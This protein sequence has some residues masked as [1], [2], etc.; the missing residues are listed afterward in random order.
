MVKFVKV[1]GIYLKGKRVNNKEFS[2]L[3]FHGE[4]YVARALLHFEAAKDHK[5][6][7]RRR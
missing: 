1:E 5:R 4:K 3:V 7:I 2:E 6:K